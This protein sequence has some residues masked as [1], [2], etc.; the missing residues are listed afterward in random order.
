MEAPGTSA[1]IAA[2]EKPRLCCRS[3]PQSLAQLRQSIISTSLAAMPRHPQTRQQNPHR[4]ALLC[5][6]APLKHLLALDQAPAPNME[7]CI[8]RAVILQEP[9]IFTLLATDTS[10]ITRIRQHRCVALRLTSSTFLANR[11]FACQRRSTADKPGRPLWSCVFSE[12]F[13]VLNTLC[14]DQLL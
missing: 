13:L 10:I 11:R 2:L 3:L 1:V 8:L 5:P 12:W 6:P 14:R 7:L 9:P 4:K